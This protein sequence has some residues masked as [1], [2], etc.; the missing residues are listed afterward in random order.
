MWQSTWN[1]E[2]SEKSLL[3]AK[4]GN[5]ILTMILMHKIVFKARYITT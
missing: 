1:T 5:N 2:K 3:I 4:L